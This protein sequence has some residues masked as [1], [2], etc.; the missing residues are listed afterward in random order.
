MMMM[1]GQIQC[2]NCELVLSEMTKMM[3]A[4]KTMNKKN[5]DDK[6]E[7][8]NEFKAMNNELKAKIKVLEKECLYPKLEN[9]AIQFLNFKRRIDVLKSKNNEGTIT[10]G[11]LSMTD[12]QFKLKYE[13]LR[14]SRNEETHPQ[15]EFQLEEYTTKALEMI[16]GYNFENHGI[17][18][19]LYFSMM[20]IV[21]PDT[22]IKYLNNYH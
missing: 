1:N 17:E 2:R 16:E 14:T 7:M 10:L 12:R 22:V 19:L 21:N 5:E 3:E 20:I 11:Q 18:S 15:S 9:A 13:K 6:R 4:V 8:K